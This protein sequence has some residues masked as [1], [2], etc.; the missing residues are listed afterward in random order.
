ML[1]NNSH[2]P[3]STLPQSSDGHQQIWCRS[4][5][6]SMSCSKQ[7]GSACKSNVTRKPVLT[8][9][10]RVILEKVVLIQ[11]L[12]KF[13][14]LYGPWSFTPVF[15]RAHYRSSSW[16]RWNQSTPI[17]ILKTNLGARPKTSPRK[18]VC[19]MKPKDG[20]C[21]HVLGKGLGKCYN[22]GGLY[23]A[24]WYAKNYLRVF[25]IKTWRQKIN[26]REDWAS[27]VKET[28]DFRGP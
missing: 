10:S 21:M 24:V 28:M 16:A 23:L 9:G 15:T 22:Y 12:D 1:V 14:S 17:A 18:I 5:Q 27:A 7:E 13:C 19:M 20:C 3:I 6:F 4:L 11:V 25:K 2:Q 26:N 8:R